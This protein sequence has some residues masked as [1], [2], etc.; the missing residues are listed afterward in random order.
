M[1]L[2][3]KEEKGFRIEIRVFELCVAHG[4][5]AVLAANM[6]APGTQFILPHRTSQSSGHQ[7]FC[8]LFSRSL[9]QIS[10]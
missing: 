7:H 9:V 2:F 8:L 10:A 3:H 5:D 6:T 4:L 1:M